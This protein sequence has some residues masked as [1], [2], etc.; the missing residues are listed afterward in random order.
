MQLAL[1]KRS[2]SFLLLFL[3]GCLLLNA[4]TS[5]DSAEKVPLSEWSIYKGKHV[6]AA[7]KPAAGALLA[8][9]YSRDRLP[10]YA[11]EAAGPMSF[12][13][14][15]R[16][17]AMLA[18]KDKAFVIGPIDYPLELYL[19]GHKVYQFGLWENVYNSQSN[20]A[21]CVTA[22]ACAIHDNGKSNSLA[23]IIYPRG[24]KTALPQIYIT[25]YEKAYAAAFWRNLICFYGILA[26]SV[27]S[28]MVGIL[29]LS[30]FITG[31]G[32]D[33]NYL[34]FALTSF[35]IA[36]GFVHFTINHNALTFQT[37]LLKLSRIGL[38]LSAVS[39]LFFAMEFTRL[40]YR[41]RI[42]K[43][44]VAI[45]GAG[46]SMVL[47]LQNSKANVYGIFYYSQVFLITPSVIGVFALLAFSVWKNRSLSQIG[48]FTAFS[49]VVVASLHD[50]YYLSNA[51]SPFTWQLPYGYLALEL[52]IIL[53]LAKE[54]GL[55][56]SGLRQQ[57]QA[58]QQ[59]NDALEKAK[60][61]AE[62]ADEAKSSFLKTMAH[63]FRTPLNCIDVPARMI[64]SAAEHC[65]CAQHADAILKAS[66][67]LAATTN[68][69]LDFAAY[70]NGELTIH[71]AVFNFAQA[72][73]EVVAACGQD[74]EVK[75]LAI[76]LDVDKNV[77]EK[78]EGDR[79][80]IM[81][82]LITLVENA[83]K[84]TES[85]R[86]TI[87]I[88]ASQVDSGYDVAVRVT[89]TGIGMSQEHVDEILRSFGPQHSSFTRPFEGLGIGLTVTKH[90]LDLMG[91]A[92]FIE[93]TEGTGTQV[94]VNLR[95]KGVGSAGAV[96]ALAGKKILVVEDNK[97]NRLV[98]CKLLQKADAEVVVAENGLEA[99][100]HYRQQRFDAILMDVQMPVMDGLTAT[101]KI[102][103][104]QQER[105]Q[106]PVLGV[107]A[108][109]EETEC[110]QAGM[111]A[112]IPK[113]VN[114]ALLKDTVSAF[115]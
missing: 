112:Y 97:L 60:A 40:L 89:D 98:L 104:L 15:F 1:K 78:L 12:L 67:R 38:T 87:A 109:A 22:P 57:S 56:L 63:E 111:D 108:N 30:L 53:I 27:L 103:A 5:R 74:A 31:E 7:A 49:M 66:R 83:I 81:Q 55:L 10:E 73:G 59:R 85:G 45:V 26:F 79:S 39:F 50:M 42:I 13:T 72:A 14:A 32:T 76:E 64:R 29:Y 100:E 96:N 92:L 68:N 33:R 34:Y 94:T 80:R 102:K 46:F 86:V 84:F 101:K 6:G 61:H 106:V 43:Y 28:L 47:L 23:A 107:T 4:C 105:Y 82:M 91:G 115:L 21:H 65:D 2:L 25:T 110:L 36:L 16:V 20:Y 17:P 113:P 41:V 9:H 48:L 37:L 24:E 70:E 58:L 44:F 51:I 19:N 62:A 54:R 88:S 71:R 52:A 8:E 95:L 18:G 75:K 99:V 11:P 69:V 93:S 77:P 3:P 35:F 114:A 90:L